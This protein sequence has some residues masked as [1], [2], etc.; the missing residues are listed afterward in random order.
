MPPKEGP[1]SSAPG[2]AEFDQQYDIA[3]MELVP[4]EDASA[5][6]A[7]VAAALSQSTIEDT[8][9]IEELLKG[10]DNGTFVDGAPSLDTPGSIYTRPAVDIELPL[11]TASAVETDRSEVDI[12]LPLGE[13]TPSIIEVLAERQGEQKTGYESFKQELFAKAASLWDRAKGIAGD[14]VAAPVYGVMRGY[15]RTAAA[16]ER[17][18]EV[19]ARAAERTIERGAQLKDDTVEAVKTFSGDVA[20][21]AKTVGRGIGTAALVGVGA[22]ILAAEGVAKIVKGGYELGGR[23]ADAGKEFVNSGIEKVRQTKEDAFK[24]MNAAKLAVGNAVTGAKNAVVAKTRETLDGGKEMIKNGVRSVVEAG[25]AVK[26]RAQSRIKSAWEKM[27][28]KKNQIMLGYLEANRDFRVNLENWR[29]NRADKNINKQ[30][31]KK[32]AAQ[33]RAFAAVEKAEK[34]RAAFTALQALQGQRLTA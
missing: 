27:K 1:E 21:G 9:P 10:M 7:E 3:G 32:A 25:V 24:K 12:P 2:S 14:V 31:D 15:Q 8:A 33:E 13:T 23:A 28:M 30:E 17:A 19:V 26:E 4:M 18:G 34:A 29:T 5:P 16:G 11:E 22:G 20:E 6:Q